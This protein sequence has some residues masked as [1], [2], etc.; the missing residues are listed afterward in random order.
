MTSFLN[1]PPAP[2]PTTFK[3]AAGREWRVR[4]TAGMLG[5]ARREASIDLAGLLTVEGALAAFMYSDPE[6]LGALLYL[7]VTDQANALGVT[8]EAFFDAFDGDTLEASIV[9]VIGAVADFSPR[10]KLAQQTRRSLPTLLERMD[11]L[12]VAAMA[13][14][15]S[16][17]SAPV[18]GSPV[19]PGSTPEASPSG[20]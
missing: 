4:I 12:A 9:A 8:P 5:R 19:P 17:S 10:S 7:L 13:A 14:S 1:D 11:G 6:K 3:D 15:L 16:T 18:G 20:S 2:P